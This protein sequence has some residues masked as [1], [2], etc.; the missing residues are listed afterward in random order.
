METGTATLH[1]KGVLKMM[2]REQALQAVETGCNYILQTSASVEEA[3]LLFDDFSNAIFIWKIC[4]L[5]DTETLQHCSIF[6]YN[7]KTVYRESVK[8]KGGC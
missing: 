2:K 4:G 1:L 6:V 8:R 7:A 5:I 3:L